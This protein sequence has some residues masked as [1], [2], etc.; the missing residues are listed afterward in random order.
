MFR[1]VHKVRQHLLL[2]HMYTLKVSVHGLQSRSNSRSKYTVYN[3][4]QSQRIQQWIQWSQT[5]I[6][7]A[8][9]ENGILGA[10]RKNP[11]WH[12]YKKTANTDLWEQDTLNPVACKIMLLMGRVASPQTHARNLPL[13]RSDLVVFTFDRM[14]TNLHILDTIYRPCAS[15]DWI[16]W[17]WRV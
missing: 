13:Y 6:L 1:H 14:S 17:F 15:F 9:E 5:Y 7:G 4:G 16:V 8:Q 12:V 10:K 3:Q 11:P 2:I